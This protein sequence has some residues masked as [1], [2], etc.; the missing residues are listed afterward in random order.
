M[1]GANPA[2][3]FIVVPVNDVVAAVFYTPV[4]AIGRKDALGVGLLRCLTGD[5]VSGFSRDH[6]GLFI[7]PFAFD[8]EGLADV[9][10]V[11]IGI[12]LASDPDLACL[13]PAMVVINSESLRLLTVLK[14]QAEIFEESGLIAF[15][16]KMI[17]SLPV[18]DQVAS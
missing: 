10:E 7:D 17:M 8:H 11:E 4:A 15:D 9:G 2:S 1:A 16:G 12:E 6:S 13:D 18:F 5:A 14:I 3:V